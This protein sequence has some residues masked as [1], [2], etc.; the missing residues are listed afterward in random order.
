VW[1]VQRGGA[2]RQSNVLS[3]AVCG[4]QKGGAGCQKER[5]HWEAENTV[6]LHCADV[7]RCCVCFAQG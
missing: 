1:G 2:G 5:L 7:G 4:E 6:D 3:R